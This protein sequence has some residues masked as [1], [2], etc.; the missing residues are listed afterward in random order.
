MMGLKM[1]AKLIFFCASQLH[2]ENTICQALCPEPRWITLVS[3]IRCN[4]LFHKLF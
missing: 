3:Q 1:G 2:L 4:E